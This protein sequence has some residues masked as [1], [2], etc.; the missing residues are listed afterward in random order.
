MEW[1]KLVSDLNDNRHSPEC[2]VFT[3]EL[4]VMHVLAFDQNICGKGPRDVHKGLSIQFVT[5]ME[6]PRLR[7]TRDRQLIDGRA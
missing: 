6:R 5:E 7:R 4:S 3:Q 2:L 1:D